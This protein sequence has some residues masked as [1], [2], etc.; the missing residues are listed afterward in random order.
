MKKALSL[1][2]AL[3]FIL[4]A[5]AQQK[6]KLSLQDIYYSNK[7]F[8]K[9]VQ[10]IQWKPDGSAFTFT[11][12]NPGEKIEDIYQHNVATGRKSLLVKGTDLK[13]DGQQIKMSHYQWTDDG[14][15]LLIEGPVKS[16]WR[17]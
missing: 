2:F 8:G 5:F 13:I 14:K 7:F 4:P 15:F 11:E 6:E 1:L 3:L 9:T 10:N 17:H 16:I 12:L